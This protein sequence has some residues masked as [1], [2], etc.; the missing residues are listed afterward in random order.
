MTHG[1]AALALAAIR[2]VEAR[3]AALLAGLPAADSSARGG[4]CHV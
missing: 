1:D 3:I 4:Y 2:L